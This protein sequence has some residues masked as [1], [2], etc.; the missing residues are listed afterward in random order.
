LER[1]VQLPNRLSKELQRLCVGAW[2]RLRRTARGDAF[3]RRRVCLNEGARGRLVVPLPVTDCPC[4]RRRP[5]MAGI[6]HA[7]AWNSSRIDD[8]LRFERSDAEGGVLSSQVCLKRSSERRLR[9]C[10]WRKPALA[11]AQRCQRL[12][13][14]ALRVGLIVA[15]ACVVGRVGQ[16]NRGH[17]QLFA[18]PCEL[19]AACPFV[20]SRALL[21]ELLLLMRG[22]MRCVLL[23]YHLSDLLLTV[24]TQ[25]DNRLLV[26]IGVL[27]LLQLRKQL[28]VGLHLQR[29]Q[30]LLVELSKLFYLLLMLLLLLQTLRRQSLCSLPRDERWRL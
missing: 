8:V 19:S 24:E 15:E 4:I 30:L 26:P 21:V 10:S 25:L 7:A 27:L 2:E 20:P 1:G 14:N 6:E 18:V 3:Y 12:F 28:R 29:M 17:L 9:G 5:R 11:D 16:R 13:A 23:G 22:Q